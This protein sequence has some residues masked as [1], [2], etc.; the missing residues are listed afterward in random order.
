MDSHVN[1][2]GG[3]LT[4][5]YGPFEIRDGQIMTGSSEK[6]DFCVQRPDGPPLSNN[7]SR[8]LSAWAVTEYNNGSS[9]DTNTGIF[10]AP[11]AGKYRFSTSMAI[12]L[13]GSPASGNVFLTLITQLPGGPMLFRRRSF[14]AF[15]TSALLTS[16][17]SF[18]AEIYLSKG[19]IC[20]L[21]LDNQSGQP[22]SISIGD[23]ASY[24][25]GELIG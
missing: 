3:N 7:S 24:L 2:R 18:S 22:V 16:S 25:C 17:I 15:S 10:T 5:K 13:G 23:Q 6:I 19:E 12:S 9:F 4:G 1:K 20:F 21:R 14:V 8:D 11:K